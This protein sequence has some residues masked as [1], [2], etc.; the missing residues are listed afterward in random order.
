MKNLYIILFILGLQ[1][2]QAQDKSSFNLQEAV[3]FAMKNNANIKKAENNVLKAQKKVWETT[4]M[5]LPQ[6]DATASY[7]K[8]IE[9]PVQLMPA[10][11][12]NPMAPPDTYVPVKF[13]T[14]QN[15]KWSATLKQLIFS[16]SY[17]VGL[18]SS[19]TYKQISENALLKTKQ[20]IKEVVVNAY[21]N[22]L[23]ADES[24]K[25]MQKNIETVEKNLFE[26]G[27]M[28]ENGLVEETD[29]EQLKITLS[30]LKNQMDYLQRMRNVA[31]EMLNY[32]LGR[33]TSAPLQL[34]D[35][36]E[37]LKEQNMQLE[38]LQKSFSPEQ[39]I[40]Y[41]IVKNQEKAK[42]LQV[43]FQ[44]S[45]ALPTIAAFVNYGKNAYNNDFEFFED[46]QPWYE[47]SIF[48]ININI[49]VFSS[50]GRQ[51]KLRQAKL[52][53]ENARTDVLEKEK[54]LRLQ[55]DKAKNEY[56]HSFKNYDIAKENLK[57]AEKIEHKEQ[58]KFTEGVGNSFQLNQARMQL[59][60]SQQQYLQSIIDIINKKVALENLLGQ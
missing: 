22:A 20:K 7:Q 60:Q 12:M 56:E 34:T 23:L 46:S 24:L 6:I 57:L 40:D 11:I 44:K 55:Y 48:G 58:V 13:G 50:F 17:I 26:V 33:D 31:Y 27:Q 39:N 14:E 47:Q 21:G 30:N 52:D 4:S 49:P 36:I 16:G 38:L 29:V 1:L 51:A 15:M 37:S 42:K 2:L 45:Q 9:Q 19:K 43:K 41:L 32:T 8:F 28:Y 3:D 5:G 53:Y 25:I 18:Q 35:D 59:Y 54:E 10:R